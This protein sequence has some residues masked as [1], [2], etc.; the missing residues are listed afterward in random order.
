MAKPIRK[1]T[2]LTI[3]SIESVGFVTAGANSGAQIV[4]AKRDTGQKE[5]N[6]MAKEIKKTTE[7][8]P[9]PARE[10]AADAANQAAADAAA[11]VEG[12]ESAEASPAA[13]VATAPD[14]TSPEETGTPTA[15]ATDAA[16]AADAAPS[17]SPTAPAHPAAADAADDDGEDVEKAAMKAQIAVLTKR[18]N[19][20]DDAALLVESV[21]K[22]KEIG[23]GIAKADD[24]GLF[25]KAAR[26]SNLHP[27]QVD[28]IE[29][30]LKVAS[31][32]IQKGELFTAV[33]DDLVDGEMTPEEL[34]EKDATA[35]A[36]AE[37]ITVAEAI[38]KLAEENPEKYYSVN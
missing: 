36:K 34:L 10:A 24:L 33:G 16:P 38:V 35:L 17:E 3:N 8:H 11:P 5:S 1:K 12:E 4:L 18:L 21:A 31:T 23:T 15:S 20:S 28:Y 6:I 25:L 30:V 2:E 29:G 37:K 22:A 19:E 32:R 9:A 13:P 26:S 7:A 14:A 27:T